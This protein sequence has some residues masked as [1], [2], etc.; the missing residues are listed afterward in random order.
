MQ[1]RPGYRPVR[2]TELRTYESDLVDGEWKPVR[3]LLGITAFG[4]NGYVARKPGDVLIEDHSEA[5]SGYEEL[6]VVVNGEVD[7]TVENEAGVDETFV[8]GPG[9]LVFVPPERGRTASARTEDAAV[10]AVGAVPG[11]AF[12]VS[13]WEAKR[14]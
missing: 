8:A 10:L 11:Q 1:E 9:T 13:D 4:T 12:S 5:T 3:H 14:I 7:F 2:I 6:Y